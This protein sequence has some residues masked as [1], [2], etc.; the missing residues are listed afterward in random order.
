MYIISSLSNKNYFEV[1]NNNLILSNLYKEFQIINIELNTYILLYKS[2][3]QLLGI[4]NN[5]NITL[6]NKLEGNNFIKI[7]W[8]LIKI[9]NSQFLILNKYNHKFLKAN[10]TSIQ[11]SYNFSFNINNKKK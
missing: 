10:D 1:D 5:N 9:E 3:S 6:Y 4:D 7:L 2:F 8:N 11:F